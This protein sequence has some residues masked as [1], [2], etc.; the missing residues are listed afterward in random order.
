MKPLLLAFLFLAALFPAAGFAG[1]SEP[2]VS[3]AVEAQ[4]VT[5]QNG[6]VEGAGIISGGLY[7]K[8]AEGWK[9]YWRTPGEVGTPPTI[10][11]A[12]SENIAG[13]EFLWPAPARFRAFGIENFGYKNEVLFP[14]NITLETPG[15]PARLEGKVQML[16]CSVVCVPQDFTLNLELGRGG[17]I[18]VDSATLIADWS[19]RVPVDGPTSGIAIETAT[20]SQD[21]GEALVVTARSTVPFKSPDVFPEFAEVATFGPADIRL[22]DSGRLLW[23]KVPVTWREPDDRDITI[24]ITDASRAATLPV[25]SLSET[26]A[27]PPYTLKS[28][29]TSIWQVL[30]MGFV[31]LLGGL[32]LNIMPCVLPVLSIKLTSAIKARGQSLGRIRGGFLM[33]AA[34][35]MVFMWVLAGATLIARSIGLTVGWGL[36]FQS[37]VFL[38]AMIVLLCLFAANL[39]GLYEFRLPQSITTRLA[40]ASGRP[41]YAGDF[42][43]GSF[44]AVLATP[45]SA[46]LLGTAVAFA[47]AGRPVD[48]FIIFSALGLGLALPYL[49]VAARPKMVYALPKPGRW[50]LWAKVILGGL[51]AATTVWLLWVL[52]GVAGRQIASAVLGLMLLMVALLALNQLKKPILNTARLSLVGVLVVAAMAVPAFREVEASVTSVSAAEKTL[53]DWVAFDRPAIARRVSE[54]YVVFVDVTADWCI[55]CKANKVLVMERGD[56]ARLLNSDEVIAMQADWTRPNEEISRFLEA[57]GRY[58]IPFDAV[59][60]PDAP[61]GILLPEVLSQS[62]VLEAIIQAGGPSASDLVDKDAPGEQASL[63]GVDP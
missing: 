46:P 13:V 16:T 30:R 62:V 58:G 22:G 33:S 29:Q 34:G 43:T 27:E 31:A 45:C 48:I 15:A 41:T 4:L 47:L 39:F 11:W 24:T 54:G 44:A 38:A 40:N 57:N 5:A 52:D 35:V 9:T 32:I 26:P 1:K 25:L 19:N 8:L 55:T 51:L 53:I 2:F 7:I 20:L 12:G 49:L 3:T 56:V 23:A 18:D 17:D 36:Q 50:M 6:V 61:E 14:L 21:G 60:G 63:Q 42:A 28:R 10:D 37:P 59:F